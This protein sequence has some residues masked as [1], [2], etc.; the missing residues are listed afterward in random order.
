MRTFS[1]IVLCVG[2]IF[3]T[4]GAGLAQAQSVQATVPFNFAVGRTWLPAGT[5]EISQT[6]PDLIAIRNA[7]TQR[8]LALSIVQPGNMTPVRE[9]HLVFHRYGEEYF[10]SEIDCPD[11]S[12]TASL[13]TSKLEKKAQT[14]QEEASMDDSGVVLLAL[15]R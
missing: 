2:A 11:A 5:Y 4:A 10:L 9:G 1:S 8:Q 7:K 3:V 14:R 12:M 6:S 15:N 13:P